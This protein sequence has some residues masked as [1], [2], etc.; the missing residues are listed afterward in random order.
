MNLAT[1]VVQIN[2]MA[3]N[4]KELLEKQ[5]PQS[6]SF[7][8]KICWFCQ[9]TELSLVLRESKEK[10]RYE[11]EEDIWIW[12]QLEKNTKFINADICWYFL[13]V[14]FK[15]FILCVKVTPTQKS[16]N[17]PAVPFKSQVTHSK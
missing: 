3:P 17:V 7:T 10:Y 8:Y 1:E 9:H 5:P 15:I 13:F 2:P 11:D 4:T 16:A 14:Y 12:K 6:L